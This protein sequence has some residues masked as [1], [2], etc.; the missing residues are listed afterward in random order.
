MLQQEEKN[1]LYDPIKTRTVILSGVIDDKLSERVI[2]NLLM[3]EKKA[4]RPIQMIINSP[5]GQVSSGMA[6]YDVMQILQ[7]PIYTIVAGVAASMGTILAVGGEQGYCMIT[8]NSRYMIHQPLLQG[9]IGKASDLKITAE[10]IKKTKEQIANIYATKTKKKN[11]VILKDLEQ[12]RWFSAQETLGY[13]LT[14]AIIDKFP[15]EI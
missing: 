2:G 9:V 14:D 10:E 5:G 7:S 3:L 8:A 12:D 4:V 6:I 1:L 13:K 11:S 15:L